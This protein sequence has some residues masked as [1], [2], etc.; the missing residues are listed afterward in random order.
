MHKPKNYLSFLALVHNKEF[1]QAPILFILGKIKK[2][3]PIEMEDRKSEEFTI[4]VMKSMLQV[5]SVRNKIFS[6]WICVKITG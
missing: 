2:L 3:S 1:P 6:G 5:I 4:I